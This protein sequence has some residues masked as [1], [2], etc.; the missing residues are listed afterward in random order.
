M[1]HLL[2]LVAT[3]NGAPAI[4]LTRTTGFP[5]VSQA[6]ACPKSYRK[7]YFM[8]VK[9]KGDSIYNFLFQ[10]NLSLQRLLP[11]PV[12]TDSPFAQSLSPLQWPSGTSG[13]C[14]T[15]PNKLVWFNK[16]RPN[17]VYISLLKGD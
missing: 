10:F 13:L 6:A 16:Y 3:L 1:T 14:E 2:W 15:I 11:W 7:L 5:I 17:T 4:Y 9:S 12:F 8:F